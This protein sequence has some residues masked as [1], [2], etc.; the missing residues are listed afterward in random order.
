MFKNNEYNVED[1]KLINNNW[2]LYLKCN[3]SGV[4]NDVSNINVT[5]LYPKIPQMDGDNDEET[6]Q[7][8]MEMIDDPQENEREI[9]ESLHDL[10]KIMPNTTTTSSVH[11]INF[12]NGV[13]LEASSL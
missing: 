1:I 11:G 8:L 4:T 6:L 5:Y 13:A 12:E 3:R 9:E 7:D 10:D 2:M